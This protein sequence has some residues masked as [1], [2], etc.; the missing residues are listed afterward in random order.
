VNHESNLQGIPFRKPGSRKT[1][2][3][4]RAVSRLQIKDLGVLHGQRG[5]GQ[6]GNLFV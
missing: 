1:R 6:T 3:P 4:Q 2:W 5:N